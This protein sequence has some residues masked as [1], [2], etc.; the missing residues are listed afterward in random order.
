MIMSANIY[1]PEGII[2]VD[3]LVYN[4]LR[5]KTRKIWISYIPQCIFSS[6]IDTSVW[7]SKSGTS[8]D[9]SKEKFSV[10]IFKEESFGSNLYKEEYFGTN[11]YGKQQGLVSDYHFSDAFFFSTQFSVN[12]QIEI[13]EA[14]LSKEMILERRS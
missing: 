4:P 10:T 1:A 11:L 12:I 8:A 9:L 14:S 13:Q 7:F 6:E 5:S 3:N 2:N